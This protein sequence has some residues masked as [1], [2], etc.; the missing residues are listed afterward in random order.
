MPGI[1]PL[2]EYYNP[3]LA[4]Y[5]SGDLDPG[6]GSPGT[7]S[8]RRIVVCYN[9]LSPDPCG[10]FRS[11]AQKDPAWMKQNFKGFVAFLRVRS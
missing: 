7:G 9:H 4:N 8:G 10:S 1:Y 11:Q 6:P 5:R 2:I 3:E